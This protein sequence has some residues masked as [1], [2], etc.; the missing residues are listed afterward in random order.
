M[1]KTKTITADTFATI[2]ATIT[3]TVIA[4][5]AWIIDERKLASIINTRVNIPIHGCAH[6]HVHI[7]ITHIVCVIHR[8]TN[9]CNRHSA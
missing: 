1:D 4:C 2:T 7:H 9:R 5:G 6:I 8:H 3:A